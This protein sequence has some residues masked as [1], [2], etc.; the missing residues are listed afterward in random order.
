MAKKSDKRKII[1]LVCKACGGRHYYTTKNTMNVPDKIELL[2]Y[3][4]VKRVRTK[5]TETKK[6][7][8]RNV[9]PVRR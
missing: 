8:G 7:L 4:P 9:V 5:Q 3:C 6:N 1:G 2:K